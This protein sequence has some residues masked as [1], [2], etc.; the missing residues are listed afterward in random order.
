MFELLR[1]GGRFGVGV[2]GGDVFLLDG[3]GLDVDVEGVAGLLV[4]CDGFSEDVD[5][6]AIVPRL[7]DDRF[8]VDVVDVV[9]LVDK[10]R[11]RRRQRR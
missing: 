5:G 11:W 10:G 6:V 1:A 7:V 4:T 3:D 2:I 9:R 8:C